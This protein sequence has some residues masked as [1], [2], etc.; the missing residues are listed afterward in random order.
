MSAPQSGITIQTGKESSVLF[1]HKI[2]GSCTA[3]IAQASAYDL[4]HLSIMDINTGAKF[5]IFSFLHKKMNKK[6]FA[7]NTIGKSAILYSQWRIECKLILWR[8]L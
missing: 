4:L 2:F 8:R 3:L 1:C 5:H 6:D 7:D